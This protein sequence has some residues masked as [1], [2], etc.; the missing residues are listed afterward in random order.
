MPWHSQNG[1]AFGYEGSYVEGGTITL[2]SY[3]DTH[4]WGHMEARVC[5]VRDASSCTTPADFAG[6]ELVFDSDLTLAG[7]HPP[8]PK[9]TNYPERGMFAGMPNGAQGGKME[10]AFRFK[11]P[12]GISGEKVLLQWKY[13]TANSVSNTLLYI[14]R[15]RFRHVLPYPH[16]LSNL[17][18]PSAHQLGMLTTFRRTPI[19]PARIGVKVFQ[20][21][22]ITPMMVVLVLASQ[23]VS[24]MG[25]PL[26]LCT[27]LLR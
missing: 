15:I 11:L 13:I 6:K 19:Y 3:L 10:F 1:L 5:V 21:A 8:M 20:L 2:R 16:I 18:F 9:D 25:K 7:N 23:N 27:I 22:L 24:L 4:H 26:C 17:L 12:M 14:F